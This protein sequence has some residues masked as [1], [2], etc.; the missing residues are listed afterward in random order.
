[1]D[2][3]PDWLIE[4]NSRFH[5]IITFNWCTLGLGLVGPCL[6]VCLVVSFFGAP[7]RF[8]E[9]KLS[10]TSTVLKIQTQ[11]TAGGVFRVGQVGDDRW[12]K[13]REAALCVVDH[14]SNGRR[15]NREAGE[16]E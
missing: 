12:L 1:M 9:K 6:F 5:A 7:H 14:G 8:I 16:V 15:E 11:H 13:R 3:L 4:L 10:S 2:P